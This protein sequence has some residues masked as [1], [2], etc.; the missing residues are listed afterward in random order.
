MITITQ[1]HYG[2]KKKTENHS[3]GGRKAKKKNSWGK[4][5]SIWRKTKIVKQI[6]LNDEADRPTDRPSEAQVPHEEEG[7]ED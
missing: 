5:K 4:T 1:K 2:E 7:E 6:S 3:Q